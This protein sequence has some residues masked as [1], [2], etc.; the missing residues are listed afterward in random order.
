[1]KLNGNRKQYDTDN[2]SHKTE[3]VNNV[4]HASFVYSYC[5]KV[6]QLK[7]PTTDF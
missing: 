1:M 7:G 2:T 3:A 6:A 4:Y 5:L